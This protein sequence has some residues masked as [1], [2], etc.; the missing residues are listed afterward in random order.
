MAILQLKELIQ[1]PALKEI[2]IINY[3][4]YLHLP[5]SRSK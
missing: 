3:C 2:L 4:K 1:H 5:L